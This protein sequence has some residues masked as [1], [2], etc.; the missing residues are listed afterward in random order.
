MQ[1]IYRTALWVQRYTARVCVWDLS[2]AGTTS[3]SLRA[4]TGSP[5][6]KLTSR[7]FTRR[8]QLLATRVLNFFHKLLADALITGHFAAASGATIKL[9]SRL[10]T[11]RIQL[12]ATRV[13]IWF[14]IL[15]TMTVIISI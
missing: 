7:L 9:T 2:R 3:P 8:I 12:L 13:L 1:A 10:F 4:Q 6:I 5:T 14:L 15:H 11:R